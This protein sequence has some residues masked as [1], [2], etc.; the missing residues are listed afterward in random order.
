MAT[1]GYGG[2]DPQQYQLPRFSPSPITNPYVPPVTPPTIPPPAG[3]SDNAAPGG[4]YWT[5][6]G[7]GGGGGMGGPGWANK[8][9]SPE[10]LTGMKGMY[11]A[12]DQAMAGMPSLAGMYQGYLEGN[13]ELEQMQ[14]NQA[15]ARMRG[16]GGAARESLT[17]GMAGRRGGAGAGAYAARMG[18]IGRSLMGGEQELA[19]SQMMRNMA[20][21]EGRQEKLIGY[22][23]QDWANKMGGLG[24]QGGWVGSMLPYEQFNI[25]FPAE[26]GLQK[27]AQGLQRSALEEQINAGRRAE[28][29]GWLDR[30]MGWQGQ[31]GGQY[32]AGQGDEMGY[33]GMRG[34]AELGGYDPRWLGYLQQ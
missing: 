8:M 4:G 3:Q 32:Y 23:G 20:E 30:L 21:R 14:Y 25:Q 29:A 5:P 17:R 18:D 24:Q 34:E 10:F 27:G 2:T 11:G 16:Q 19:I 9:Y 22:T 12:Y 26:Y 33:A 1:Q 7:G 31:L 13:P 6:P 28:S 15:L